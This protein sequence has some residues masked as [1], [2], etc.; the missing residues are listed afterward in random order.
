MAKGKKKSNDNAGFWDRP[1]LMNLIADLLF[2]AAALALLAV[3]RIFIL[4][5]A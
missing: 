1:Q 2:F 4:L 5:T 3:Q